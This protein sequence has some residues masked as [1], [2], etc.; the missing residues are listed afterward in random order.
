[1]GGGGGKGGGKSKTQVVRQIA[2]PQKPAEQTTEDLTA[3]EDDVTKKVS[4]KGAKSLSI[5][6]VELPVSQGKTAVGK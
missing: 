5:P 4:A 1:M 3:V 6:V 2:P